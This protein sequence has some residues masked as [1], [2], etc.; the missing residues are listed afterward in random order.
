M[1]CF[2]IRNRDFKNIENEKKCSLLVR[3][4]LYN[5]SNQANEH[6]IKEWQQSLKN[7]GFKLN[8]RNDISTHKQIGSI[9]IENIDNTEKCLSITF[10]RINTLL[11]SLF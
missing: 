11:S 10:D 6:T 5:L 7:H 2:E 1:P 9:C 8:H 3:V 4:V